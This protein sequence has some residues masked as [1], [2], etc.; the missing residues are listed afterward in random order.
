MPSLLE[1]L[2]DAVAPAFTV[3]HE[4]G[5]GGMGIVFLGHD[6]A[7]DRPVAI[8]VL[9]PELASYHAAA[10]FLR[11]ARL[12]AKLSHPNIVPIHQVGEKNGLFYYVM[13]YIPGDTVAVRLE[14]GLMN[15]A[16]VVA[17][18]AD[19]LS[20]LEAVHRYGIVHR[21][22]KPSN[23]F[24]LP[25]RAILADFGI[26]QPSSDPDTTLTGPGEVVGTLRYMAPEQRV[27][28][29]RVNH[30]ADLYATG[31][32]LYEALTGR[33]PRL[34][35]HESI[36][37]SGIPMDRRRVLRRALEP[38]ASRRWESARAFRAALIHPRLL[39]ARMGMAGLGAFVGIMLTV[40]LTGEAKPVAP[41]VPADLAVLPF[42]SFPA[43][44][45]SS[46]SIGGTGRE[47]SRY[48]GDRLQWFTRWR[49]QPSS[50]TFAWADSVAPAERP[51][52]APRE[53]KA[54]YIAGGRLVEF[55]GGLVLELTIRDS[56]GRALNPTPMR[57]AGQPDDLPAWSQQVADSIV[58][59]A[60]PE[61]AARFRELSRRTSAD[62]RA[63][64]EYFKGED[65]FQ[66]DAYDEA[67]G[68]YR[69]A[70]QRDP[71]FVEAAL[72]LAIV[73]RFRRVPFEADLKALYDV[74]GN[75]LPEQHR[76]LIEALL[77]P[78]L[79]RRF[80]RYRQ[81]VAAFPTDPTVRF[82]Y[83]DE[84]FHRGPL[85]G[86]PLDSAVAELK[87]LTML[88]ADL[89][90]APTYDHLLWGHLRLGR[91][92]DADSSLRER[93]RIPFSGEAEEAR[94]RRFLQLA[95]DERFRPA[96][97]WVKYR[98][99][100]LWTD[101]TMLDGM[102][103]YARLG[104]AFDLPRAQLILG[105]ILAQKGKSLPARASGQRAQGLALMLLG[106]P[107]EAMGHLDS[108]VIWL[109]QPDSALERAEWRILPAMLGLPLWASTD[110]DTSI[111]RLEALSRA[112]DPSA[113]PAW[114]LA[115]EATRTGDTS[116][117]ARW[118]DLVDRAAPGHRGAARLALELAAV[119]AASRGRLDSALTLSA[120]LLAYD[121]SGVVDDP[122]A[123]AVLH[124]ERGHWFLALGDTAKADRELLWY[125]N[126]DSGIEGW[127]HSEVQP[128]EVDA[129]TSGVVRLF[130]G[131]LAMAR[132]DTARACGF[133]PRVAELWAAAEPPYAALLGEAR[134]LAKSCDQ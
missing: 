26:A 50:R 28:S 119:R 96:V 11:E 81:V 16:E 77:E 66:R 32:V 93:L 123:R 110:R 70:L 62:T 99:L 39:R 59:R 38:D 25:D 118:A 3:E 64:D 13:D 129:V 122:F 65:A 22:V 37:W 91:R 5:R 114:A 19:L 90:Q 83:A 34:P 49:F 131:R 53:L 104:N 54:A 23:I 101:S 133:V 85:V 80:E 76:Q 58:G 103:R 126:S 98:W 8:K 31:V 47:L 89:E 10:R 17:L 75:E 82:V 45:S 130:R 74:S 48:T 35:G 6:V 57:V 79:D 21:D 14:R 109:A 51:E 12:L 7:L 2:Q 40:W 43:G 84:L 73:R 46:D 97:A 92:A 24:L 124:W 1:H 61:L 4:I 128:G 121:S 52:R 134:T 86:V 44:R 63:Y 60:F 120:P 125:E 69:R 9:Q 88:H 55:G 27:G 127:L 33:V 107:A 115:L 94:R 116:R 42:E 68:Y 108:A 56:S 111:A 102:Q 78:D 41:S 15:P 95:Y 105:G 36:N 100:R 71:A 87:R 18:G 113:R 117:A 30:R 67:D 112:G 20:G 29:E 132:H 72:R 106:R